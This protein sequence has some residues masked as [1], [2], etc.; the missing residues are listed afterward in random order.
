DGKIRPIRGR[1][2]RGTPRKTDRNQIDVLQ[3][4]AV[5]Q[6][7][8]A[9]DGRGFQWTDDLHVRVRARGERIISRHKNALRLE[10]KIE[11]RFDQLWKCYLTRNREWPARQVAAEAFDM[12]NIALE[13]HP[14][15]EATDGG[16]RSVREPRHV[17]RDVARAAQ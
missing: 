6:C 10:L 12:E 8:I 14:G 3:Q 1:L 2:R 7:D 11:I 16:Q 13:S 9:G 15:M 5:R 4:R 17:D